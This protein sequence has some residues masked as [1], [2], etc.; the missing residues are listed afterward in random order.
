MTTTTLSAQRVPAASSSRVRFGDLLSAEWIKFWS[1]RSTRLTFGIGTPAIVAFV[2]F[3]NL[4]STH[5]SWSKLGDTI[6]TRFDPAHAIFSGVPWFLLMIGVAT[7]GAL[8]I[9][10]EH[11]SGLIRT[12]FTAV[13]ARARVVLAKSVVM[14]VV[15][16]IMGLIVAFASYGIG[17]LIMRG[18]D[19]GFGFTAPNQMRS[20]LASALLLPICAL[21]GM[22]IAAIIRNVPATVFANTVVFAIL[23]FALKSH[24]NRWIS[25]FSNGLVY[26]AW[27]GLTT[28]PGVHTVGQ[29]E[30]TTTCSWI[31]FVA[32]PVVAVIIATFLLKRRDV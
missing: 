21:G 10:G 22:G 31:T 8:S 30:V 17:E 20:V 1:L 7:I 12:T 15:M 18:Q 11:S 3:D 32:W 23:P 16:F 24:D 13:P 19:P 2:E 6:Q 5:T 9:A 26:Y 14:A 25:D 4:W 28:R 27:S 29:F